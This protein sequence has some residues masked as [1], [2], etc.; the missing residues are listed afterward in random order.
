MKE[1]NRAYFG[2]GPPNHG[3]VDW[4][5]QPQQ[6]VP[7]RWDNTAVKGKHHHQQQQQQQQQQQFHLEFFDHGFW[8][9][10][11]TPEGSKGE[12]RFFFLLGVWAE[13]IGIS[14]VLSMW[15]TEA[16]V[17]AKATKVASVD[18]VEVK[19][20]EMGKGLGPWAEVA[21]VVVLGGCL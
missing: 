5:P 12:G 19:M 6:K 9:K 17:W 1:N 15:R 13:V 8:G 2:P 16:Q 14:I 21:A 7:P 10:N 4:L 18:G 3:E 11:A 20:V